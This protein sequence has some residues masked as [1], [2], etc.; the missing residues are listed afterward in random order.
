MQTAP[1]QRV[2]APPTPQG[3]TGPTSAEPVVTAVA[4]AVRVPPQFSEL[5]ELIESHIELQRFRA[6]TDLDEAELA[7][8]IVLAE[9]NVRNLVG[10]LGYFSRTIRITRE[11]GVNERATIVVAIDPGE[12]TLIGPVAVNFAGD[13]AQSADPDAVNQREGIQRGWRLPT[14]RTF[15]QDAW[16]GA[17]TQ[18]LRDLVARRYPAGKVAGSLADVEAPNRTASLLLSLD[19]GPLYR[20]GKME[21]TGVERYN[22]VLVPRLARLPQ[23]A[24]YDQDKLVEAQQRLAS[25]GYFDSAY[26][27]IDPDSDPLAA[28]VQVQV[29]EA[30]LQKIILGVGITTDSGPRASVELTHLRVPGIGWRAATKLQLEKKSPFAQTEWT[31]IPDES[32]WRW[33]ALARAEHLDDNELITRGQRLRFGRTRDLDVAALWPDSLQT[34]LTGSASIRPAESTP[35]TLTDQ[36]WLLQLQLANRL[37][38]PWDRQRLPLDRVEAQ[39]EWRAGAGIVRS[40]KAQLGGSELLASGEWTGAPAVLPSAPSGPPATR[41]AAPTQGWKLKATLQNVNPARLHSQLAALPLDAQ[42]NLRSQGAA[43]GFEASA[44]EANS[45]GKPAPTS[46]KT[47]GKNSPLREM[48]LR[49]ASATGSWN[50]QQAGGTLSLSTLRVRT[51]DAE[52]SGRLEFQPL[53]Q[54]GKGNLAL[55]APG[56]EAK[57]Q[58]E[59]RPGSGGGDLSLRGRDAALAAAAAGHALCGST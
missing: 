37:P 40:L 23:G 15:T 39:G 22:P 4:I 47:S 53:A 32:S 56:L 58:G 29:R 19:S 55:T 21:V 2:E 43:L 52:L 45:T 25:S 59:L 41:P 51:D 42:A 31:S 27:F 7:R 44:Q 12:A 33:I 18:A 49:N 5:R 14:R 8:L 9:R 16:N 48:R 35:A 1:P 6:V 13:I 34:L 38:D 28:P 57:V 24:V 36:A 20:L 54:N 50:G 46:Q 10:T 26:V 11:V 3:A 30:K 17:K